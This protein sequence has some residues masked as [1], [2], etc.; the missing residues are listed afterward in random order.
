MCNGYQMHIESIPA[1]EG[2]TQLNWQSAIK[3]FSLTG[4]IPDV[5]FYEKNGFSEETLNDLVQK[6]Y[7]IYEKES[8]G[9]ANCI[10][11]TSNDIKFSTSDARRG[12][13]AKAY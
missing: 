10:Q 1:V 8:I 12:A 11:V 6:G 4:L 9:E 3:L 7:D 13:S 5:I 2:K